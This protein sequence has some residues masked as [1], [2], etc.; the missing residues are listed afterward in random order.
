MMQPNQCHVVA[1]SDGFEVQPIGK[2]YQSSKPLVDA[3][4]WAQANVSL[5]TVELSSASWASMAGFQSATTR[6]SL[7]RL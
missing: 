2:F 5:A 7:G 6:I 1:H 3:A 4:R